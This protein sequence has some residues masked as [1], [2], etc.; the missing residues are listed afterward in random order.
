MQVKETAHAY[1]QIRNECE[2]KADSDT[3]LS[4]LGYAFAAVDL[5]AERV[6]KICVVL[7]CGR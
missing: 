3:P 5:V 4:N 2:P 6:P 1:D 7:K